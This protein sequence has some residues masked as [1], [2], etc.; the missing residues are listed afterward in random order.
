VSEKIKEQI[1]ALSRVLDEIPELKFLGDHVLRTP[2]EE[3]SVEEGK[4]IGKQ[5]GKTLIKYRNVTGFGRGLAA[6]QIG[7]S[8]SVFVTFVEDVVETYINPKI[9]HKSEETNLYRELC[10]SSGVMWADVKRSAEIELEWM[11]ENGEMHKEK[12]NGMMARLLQHEEAHLR[13]VVSLD[14]ALPGTIEIVT[15]NPLDEVFRES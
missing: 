2:T 14:E 6:P 8:K 10:L 5:L 9:T 12:F 7:I 4:E 1:T 15:T 11:D 3:V 13:G